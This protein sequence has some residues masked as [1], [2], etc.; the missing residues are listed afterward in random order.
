MTL[1]ISLDDHSIIMKYTTSLYAHII[2]EPSLFKVS[3]IISASR[4]VMAIERKNRNY[5]EKI[6]EKA[7]ERYSK[8]RKI[9]DQ[10]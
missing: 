5:S 6:V 3:D 4:I 2:I 10:L 8:A 9:L 7:K 1:R